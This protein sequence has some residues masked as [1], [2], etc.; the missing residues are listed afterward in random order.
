MT[1]AEVRERLG[2]YAEGD[3]PLR[4]RA[5]V[6]AHLDACAECAAELR[7]VRE[8]IDLLHTLPDPEPPPGLVDAVMRRLEA[9]DGEPG[10]RERIASWLTPWL[11]PAWLAPAAAV[12][13]ALV[14]FL[15]LRSSVPLL[16]PA[17]EPPAPAPVVLRTPIGASAA[18]DAAE[19]GAAEPDG[20]AAGPPPEDLGRSVAL[21]PA[22]PA[23]PARAGGSALDAATRRAIASPRSFLDELDRLGPSDR[24]AWLEPLTRYAAESRLAGDVV[25]SLRASGDPRGDA[26]AQRFEEAA[27]GATR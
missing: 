2:P 20:E 26:V 13:G 7:A 14:V 11:R 6:D 1:H 10:L 21:E 22:A 19:P 8:T 5:L 12:A 17:V 18:P 23:R 24:D 27:G 4:V 9:G 3:L 16:R 15:A 25:Q